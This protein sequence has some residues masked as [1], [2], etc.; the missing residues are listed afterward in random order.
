[1]KKPT[2]TVPTGRGATP[3]SMRLITTAISRIH[4]HRPVA[5]IAAPT[6]SSTALSQPSFHH[7]SAT[8]ATATIAS[9][10]SARSIVC[11]TSSSL[12]PASSTSVALL[13]KLRRRLEDLH[14]PGN[15]AHD[16]SDNLDP[17]RMEVMIQQH[18]HEPADQAARRQRQRKLD[19]RLRLHQAAENSPGPLL[20]SIIGHRQTLPSAQ[21]APPLAD[22]LKLH[23]SSAK[24]ALQI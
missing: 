12:S 11:R 13:H 2:N 15:C 18:S 9:K 16:D 22:I 19:H 24:R 14:K 7:T 21:A 1:M 23:T 5:E 20:R 8:P 6:A 3:A 4:S 17:L 10:R